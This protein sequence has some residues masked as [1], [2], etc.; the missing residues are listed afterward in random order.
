MQV[1][2][3]R[4]EHLAQRPVVHPPLKAAM[5]RLIRRVPLGQIFPG[6][7]GA[8]DPE[9]PIQH[10]ARIAPRPAT[11]IASPPRLRKQGF[12]N[13]PLRVS[14]VHAA[15]YDGD[16]NFVHQPRLGFMR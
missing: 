9:D 13:G 16:R 12:E 10:V 3:Q 8:Q 5:T 1:G 4:L 6:R 2:R 15:E 7:A 11:P 14:E